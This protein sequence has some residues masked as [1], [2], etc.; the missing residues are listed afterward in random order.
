MPYLWALG[1][2]EYA[3]KLRVKEL[4]VPVL[5]EANSILPMLG[6]TGSAKS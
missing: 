4:M 3:D 2:G 6:N 5:A 1:A